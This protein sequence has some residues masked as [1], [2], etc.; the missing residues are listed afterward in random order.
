MKSALALGADGVAVASG[1]ETSDVVTSSMSES[2]RFHMPE[3]SVGLGP[4]F[5]AADGELIAVFEMVQDHEES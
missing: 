4:V 3:L 5:R 1:D 2:V